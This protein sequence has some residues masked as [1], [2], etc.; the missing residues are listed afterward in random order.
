M[1]GINFKDRK[2]HQ[3]DDGSFTLAINSGSETYH[4]RRGALSESQHVYVDMG[5]RAIVGSANVVRVLEVGFGTGLN[6][7]LTVRSVTSMAKTEIAQVDHLPNLETLVIT[8]KPFE[9]QGSAHGASRSK[10]LIKAK[11]G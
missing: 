1:Q 10:T 7:L 8:Q 5:F 2:L 11:L 6:A 3:T 4:S 9:N